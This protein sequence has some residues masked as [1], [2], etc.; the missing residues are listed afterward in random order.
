[1]RQNRIIAEDDQSRELYVMDKSI[2]DVARSGTS[3]RFHGS[4]TPQ[5][6]HLFYL[7]HPLNADFRNDIPPYYITSAAAGMVGNICLESTKSPLAATEF[8]ALLSPDRSAL[9]SE[10]FDG[11]DAQKLMFTAKAAWKRNNLKWKD[12]A[13]R[14][15]AQEDGKGKDGEARLVVT[16]SMSPE[17]RDALAATWALRLWHDTAESKQVKRERLERMI[18]TESV[19]SNTKL[20]KRMGA[21]GSLAGAAV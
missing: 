20:G 11:K 21:L 7:V 3:V 1:M 17:L 18:P 6:Q 2:S 5:Q 16:A 13:G 8:R 10:L 14:E 12:A 9:D 4:E 19:Y 15:V